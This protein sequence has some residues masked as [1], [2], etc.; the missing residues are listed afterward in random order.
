MG[1]AKIRVLKKKR[2]TSVQSSQLKERERERKKERLPM[3][4]LS[5][6]EFFNDLQNRGIFTRS[7][8]RITLSPSLPLPPFTTFTTIFSHSI[9]KPHMHLLI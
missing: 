8:S 3:V 9:Y 6:A 1:Y 5:L 2:W 4:F 7:K